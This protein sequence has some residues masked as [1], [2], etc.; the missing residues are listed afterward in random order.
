MMW[1]I[2]ELAPNE[3][4]RVNAVLGLARLVTE[5]SGSLTSATK[6][7]S[8]SS[9]VTAGHPSGPCLERRPRDSGSKSEAATLWTLRDGKV[10]KNDSYWKIRTT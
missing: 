8:T 2:R 9:M 5:T 6:R 3:I 1:Q 10:V 4:E 7:T